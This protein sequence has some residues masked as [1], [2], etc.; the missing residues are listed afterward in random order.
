V[1]GVPPGRYLLAVGVF[2]NQISSIVQQ[3]EPQPG[4]RVTY[5]PGTSSPVEAQLVDVVAGGAAPQ[6]VVSVRSTVRAALTG[7]VVTLEGQ[8]VAAA[9]WRCSPPDRGCGGWRADIVRKPMARSASPISSQGRTRSPRQ[10][11]TG[12]QQPHGFRAMVWMRTCDRGV[13]RR[14]VDSN[15]QRR[16]GQHVGR[17]RDQ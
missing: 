12:S 14:S 8:P 7:Q 6:L 9:G 17:L 13:W 3:T 15:D 2:A 10:V 5:D 11:R 4:G 1:H 16:A